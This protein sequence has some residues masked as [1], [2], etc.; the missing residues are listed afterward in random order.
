MRLLVPGAPGV[1]QC[2]M[3]EDNEGHDSWEETVRWIARE[4][5]RSVERVSEVDLEEIAG[6]MGVDADR[7]K[8]WVDF[9]GRWGRGQAAGRGDEV[10]FPGRPSTRPAT[11]EDPLSSAGPHPLDL[12]T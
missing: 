10:A 3:F 12:P 8:Q 2:Y 5:S 11:D 1:D 6:N 9:A 4:I 7:A